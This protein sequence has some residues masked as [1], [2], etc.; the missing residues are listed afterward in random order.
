MVS[1]SY[2][3]R[4]VDG[5]SVEHDGMEQGS[6]G[7]QGSISGHCDTNVLRLM[8]GLSPE[9][10]QTEPSVIWLSEGVCSLGTTQGISEILRTQG[11]DN[12]A[13]TETNSVSSA[14]G[15]KKKCV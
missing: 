1:V 13:A 8:A 4:A 15:G 10:V 6:A 11:A 9:S 14:L 12:G 3:D 5:T 2:R 7:G